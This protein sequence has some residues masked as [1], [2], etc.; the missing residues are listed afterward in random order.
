MIKF[1]IEQT[2]Y[3]LPEFISIENY[4]KI[5]KIKD[6]FSEDY[7][8]AKLINIVCDTPLNDLL[9]SDY[10][11]VNYM[12][13]YLMN[14]FPIDKPKFIDRFEIDGVKYGFFPNWK[15]LTFAEFVDLDT[16]S[17]KKPDEILDLLHILAA[18]MY[19]PIISEKSE[20]DYQIEKYDINKMKERAEVFKKKLDV[21]YVLGAQFFF[22]KFAK[23][24]LSY[25]QMSS[26]TNLSIWTKIRLV[27][28]L[29]KIIWKIAFK[30]HS[31]GSLSSI[32]LV[33]TILRN[34]NTSIKKT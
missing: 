9:Q 23:R 20:H 12:A 25:T 32:E 24:Y 31:D 7:F 27:W 13:T 21:K 11:H 1:K 29:R 16:I 17:T 30:K 2:E 5:Y 10:Q 28:N 18:I 19:R 33:E 4:S 14:L 22:I 6:L 15:D 26:I 8:A 3:Q 34:T